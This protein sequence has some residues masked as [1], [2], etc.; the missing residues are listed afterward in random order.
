V[1][2]DLTF[3]EPDGLRGWVFDRVRFK[4]FQ[5][6]SAGKGAGRRK[7]PTLKAV[8]WLPR[9][10]PAMVPAP[11]ELTSESVLAFC[12]QLERVTNATSRLCQQGELVGSNY[13]DE[14][15]AIG[16][17]CAA[18]EIPNAFGSNVSPGSAYDHSAIL[19]AASNLR[20]ACQSKFEPTPIA[21]KELVDRGDSKNHNKGTSPS[22]DT[23]DAQREGALDC[24]PDRLK[25]VAQ[26]LFDN[27][28]GL[29]YKEISKRVEE[30]SLFTTSDAS[31]WCSRINKAW[32]ENRVN[33]EISYR[34]VKRGGRRFIR[35]RKVLNGVKKAPHKTGLGRVGG[36][37]VKR[38]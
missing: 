20:L 31:A 21:K 2:V 34:N 6:V 13:A 29:N 26:M 25:G 1:L 7:P 33:L 5:K 28:D 9:G 19:H 23:V 36:K 35:P 12:E 38:K 15:T 11:A 22:S 17:I 30:N 27:P 32:S 4:A 24:L 14:A 3:F 18:L 10:W 16:L 8:D 37:Q